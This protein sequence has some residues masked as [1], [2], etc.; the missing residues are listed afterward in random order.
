MKNLNAISTYNT[1]SR[2]WRLHAHIFLDPERTRSNNIINH[3]SP[4][5][6]FL[7]SFQRF[8]STDVA[9]ATLLLMVKWQILTPLRA[10]LLLGGLGLN[11]K[12]WLS[13]GDLS[14]SKTIFAKKCTRKLFRYIL[15]LLVYKKQR[16]LIKMFN[17]VIS[18]YSTYY[19]NLST[20]RTVLLLGLREDTHNSRNHWSPAGEAF[21]VFLS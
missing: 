20:A 6:P 10:F 14:D 8:Q 2:T 18:T 21:A 3:W 4:A 16:V 1:Y 9:P 11:R 12:K 17:A 7:Y 5:K 15:A 19:R 13:K